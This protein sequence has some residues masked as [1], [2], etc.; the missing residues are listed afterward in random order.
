MQKAVPSPELSA[1]DLLHMWLHEETIYARKKF[2]TQQ[3]NVLTDKL[4]SAESNFG[5]QT[6]MY[7]SRLQLFRREAAHLQAAQAGAK[8]ANASKNLWA[9]IRAADWS[10]NLPAMN[11]G[12]LIIDDVLSEARPAAIKNVLDAED[13]WDTDMGLNLTYLERDL[14]SHGV[15]SKFRLGM[16]LK[17]ESVI[18]DAAQV[19]AHQFEQTLALTGN[20]PK[21]GISSGNIELWF[22][23]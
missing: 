6:A 21:P 10:D 13:F 12:L 17:A 5:G 7:W 2:G 18:A 19:A 15:A 14:R 22:P 23:E 9:T 16:L 1:P 20:L 4:L 11:T 3:A 8:M